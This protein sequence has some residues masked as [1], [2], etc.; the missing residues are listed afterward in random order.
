MAH[1]SLLVTVSAVV[2]AVGLSAS[3]GAAVEPT[4]TLPGTAPPTPQAETLSDEKVRS[5]LRRLNTMKIECS[6]QAR[7]AL[8]AQQTASFAGRTSEAEAQGQ[9]LWSRLT[10]VERANQALFRLRDQ[11]TREQ[12]RLFSLEDGFHQEYRQGLESHL[13]ILQRLSKQLADQNTLDAETFA[14]Q[15]DTFRR[16]RETFRNRYARLLNDAETHELATTLFRAGDLLIGSTQ[17]WKQQ[18]K[19]D[20]EIAELTPKGPSPELSRAQAARDAAV[21]ERARQWEMAQR[22]ILQ[23][24]VL[25][26]TR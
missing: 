26:A 18:V 23:A 17:V 1:G 11:V 10:C 19:A 6:T 24:T 2:A 20:A 8:A 22:L 13:S 14:K 3:W 7:Q 4:L 5:E 25:T 21:A 15:M 12:V 16:Q 9:I